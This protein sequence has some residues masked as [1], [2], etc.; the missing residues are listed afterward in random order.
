M[1][2]VQENSTTDTKPSVMTVE[3]VAAAKCALETIYDPVFT[4]PHSPRSL[5]K[6]KFLKYLNELGM[7]HD[8]RIIA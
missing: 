2:P 8:D 3:T 6:Q 7:P 5:R 4:E 1:I